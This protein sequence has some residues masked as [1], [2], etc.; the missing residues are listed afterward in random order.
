[1]SD[2]TTKVKDEEYIR[3]L[4]D[5]THM[6]LSKAPTLTSLTTEKARLQAE[7]VQKD[8]LFQERVRSSQELFTTKKSELV[9]R[10]KEL[11]LKIA[12]RKSTQS[13]AAIPGSIVSTAEEITSVM[14]KPKSVEKAATQIP[15]K[16]LVITGNLKKTKIT[17][18]PSLALAG[19]FAY[20]AT[21]ADDLVGKL[22]ELHPSPG[23]NPGNQQQPSQVPD[24][25]S[26]F[27]SK[28][29]FKRRLG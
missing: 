20:S 13:A 23:N 10:M 9:A 25:S 17:V 14:T 28:R 18:S 6:T 2:E 27:A 15:E 19:S 3:S 24:I 22:T 12:E 5:E 4:I 26:A 29:I 1:L 7:V 21:A 11:D 16:S 8:K